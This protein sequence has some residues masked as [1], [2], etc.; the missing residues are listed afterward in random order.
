MQIYILWFVTAL[1]AY[2]LGAIPFGFLIAKAR[3]VDIRTV[4]SK[5]IGATNVFRSVSKGAGIATFA[6]DM[7]KGFCATQYLP[8]LALGGVAETELLPL[9]VFSG[10]CVVIGHNWTCFLGFKGG[11]GIATSLGFLFGLIPLAGLLALLVWV[12][13]VALS[14]YVSLAS[15]VAAASLGGIVWWRYPTPLWLPIIINLLALLAIA[16]HHANIRRLLNGTESRI[17]FSRKN[18]ESA[19]T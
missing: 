4:G 8:M 14:R 13:V 10:V 12:V 5:N 16:K 2:L 15:I 18:G 9:R 11:K 1:C 6:L 19:R 3:G 17:S 7:G